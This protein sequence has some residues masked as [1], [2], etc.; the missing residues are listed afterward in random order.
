LEGRFMAGDS[1]A[2][3]IRYQAERI[4]SDEE[5]RNF[6]S[7]WLRHGGTI[8][9][10]LSTFRPAIR[11][12]TERR[13]LF[14]M[15]G[16]SLAGGSFRFVQW[17]PFVSTEEI[18]R[19]KASAEVQVRAEDS[20][21]TGTLQRSFT[22]I[23]QL[24]TWHLLEWNDL[25]GSVTLSARQT[26][27]EEPFRLRGNTNS[28]VV[29]V[30]SQARYSPFQRA[31]QTDVFY[32][33]SNQRSARL[34]RVYVRVAK[35]EGNYR[36]L[37]DRNGNTLPDDDEFELTRFDGDYIVLFLPGET[38]YP[39]ANLKSSVRA[40]FH[41]SRILN[42]SS[43]LGSILSP[44]STETYVRVDERSSDPITENV[45]FLRLGTFLNSQYTISGSQLVT[46][47]VHLYENQ[48]FFSSRLH[49]SQRS[50]FLQLVTSAEESYSRERSVR[51]R[52]QLISEMGNESEFIER[53][54]R[55]ASKE[56]G[57]RDRDL[58]SYVFSSDFS[59]R[60][61][62]EWEIGFRFQL[63]T[64]TDRLGGD[65]AVA[66]VN[67]QSIRAVYGFLRKGQ[68]RAEIAR[69]E[70]ILSR[71]S[72]NP[73]RTYP[74]EFTQG[75][76]FGKSFLWTLNFDYRITQN[77]QMSLH[78]NGRAEGERTPIHFVRAEAKAFF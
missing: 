55:L 9:H 59:Y 67:E 10:S 11:F 45:Y 30:R 64:T 28:D 74:Y 56:T 69:E 40:R 48:T 13:D 65:H 53:V 72:S 18:L 58:R 77:I 5:A 1:A 66:D 34:E 20:S 37:G 35:G 2:G 70:A 46:Q 16:D 33:F 62:R 7:T 21:L 43:F 14:V 17:S 68:L 42:I 8:E 78:Y 51:V 73:Q 38:L 25:S 15:P 54:D 23:T 49:F 63:E 71:P 52:S 29:M 50:G 76:V 19:M 60:P 47:D 36:H 22:S 31:L 39:V 32:E 4:S 12:D 61:E 6:R 75:R 44:V 41:P 24:Y 57:P 3:R 27:F 26:R